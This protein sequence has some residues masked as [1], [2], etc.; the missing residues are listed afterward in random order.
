[1]WGVVVSYGVAPPLALLAGWL[2]PGPP[3]YRVGLLLSAVQHVRDWTQYYTNIHTNGNVS[4]SCAVY[5]CVQDDQMEEDQS[6]PVGTQSV[7]IP[8]TSTKLRAKDPL[9]VAVRPPTDFL[10]Q[11]PPWQLSGGESIYHQAPGIDYLLPYWMLR[12]Y[13]ESAKPALDPF[14]AWPGPAHE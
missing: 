7:V 2:A 5:T 1:M 12:F 8:G 10:W 14:P 11:R 4:N 13:T 3:D 6:T 9:P